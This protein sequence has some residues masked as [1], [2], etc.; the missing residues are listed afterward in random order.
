MF[1]N[2][3]LKHLALDS[4]SI[5]CIPV[6]INPSIG[7][8][9]NLVHT[10]SGRN[11]ALSSSVVHLLSSCPDLSQCIALLARRATADTAVML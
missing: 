10:V 11:L 4:Q 5:G 3:A 6:G 8:I 2:L 7:A 9:F 1:G